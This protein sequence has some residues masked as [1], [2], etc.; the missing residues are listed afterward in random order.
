MLKL[1][2]LSVYA[3]TLMSSIIAVTSF[4]PLP[5]PS[6]SSKYTSKTPSTATTLFNQVSE[7]IANQEDTYLSLAMQSE[8]VM[9]KPDIVYVIMYNPGTENEAIHTME[10]PRGTMRTGDLLLAFESIEEVNYFANMIRSDGDFM[11]EPIPTPT[12]LIQL[13]MASQQMGLPMKVVPASS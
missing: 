11:E 5:P 8:G 4:S 9:A 7:T 3:L 1:S 6:L 13:E 2:V 10:Y 12:P